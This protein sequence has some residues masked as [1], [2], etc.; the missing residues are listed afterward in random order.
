MK[1]LAA[2]QLEAAALA[3]QQHCIAAAK[4]GKGSVRKRLEQPSA[5]LRKNLA[6]CQE[7]TDISGRMR[8]VETLRDSIRGIFMQVKNANE[9]RR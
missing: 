9:L 8:A 7:A 4:A 2:E 5:N 3:E 1:K 6:L